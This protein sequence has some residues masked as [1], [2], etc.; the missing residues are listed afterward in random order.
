MSRI[1]IRQHQLTIT[2]VKLRTN[3]TSKRHITLMQRNRGPESLWRVEIRKY[4]QN[5]R[6]EHQSQHGKGKPHRR[7]VDGL[8]TAAVA[9]ARGS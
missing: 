6:L 1:E 8:I 2:Y 7:V 4:D 5:G 9:A 3:R